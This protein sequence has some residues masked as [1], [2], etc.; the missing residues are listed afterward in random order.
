MVC[1]AMHGIIDNHIQVYTWEN[2]RTAVE[3]IG[4]LQCADGR[5]LLKAYDQKL[6]SGGVAALAAI[7]APYPPPNP[8]AL[9]NLRATLQNALR[10]FQ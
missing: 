10:S 3:F 5:A 7:A 8:A 1:D 6:E 2:H 4:Q 9:A